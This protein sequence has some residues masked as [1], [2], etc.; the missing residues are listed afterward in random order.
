MDAYNYIKD[1]IINGKFE[2]GMRLG[3][4]SLAKELKLSRTPIREAIKQLESEGLVTP[5]K[6]GVSVRH[7]THKDIQQIYDLRALLE[8][9]TASQAAL[10]RTNENLKK[11]KEA[12]DRYEKAIDR[13][14]EADL[15]SIKEVVN[16]NQQFH[17]AIISACNNPH[18]YFHLSKVVVVP[19]VFRSFYWYDAFELKRSLEVHKTIIT[20]IQN[21][22]SERSRVAMT[23]HIYQG[24]DQVLAH[25]E[26]IK[27]IHV[28]KEDT[29]D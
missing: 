22:D 7:F 13:Y 17:E 15:N 11:M 12:N 21:Q 4:E 10:H 28:L 24:R 6:R 14:K 18:I 27:K 20:A 8:G 2:P 26:E 5:L 25:L 9:Y 16:F 1:A 29:H 23:E 19:L 3:E